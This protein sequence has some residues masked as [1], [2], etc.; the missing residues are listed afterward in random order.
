MRVYFSH[1]TTTAESL[2][3]FSQET[4]SAE[5]LALVQQLKEGRDEASVRLSDLDSKAQ[6]V[7]AALATT[8]HT[9]RRKATRYHLSLPPTERV[10]QKSNQIISF[11]ISLA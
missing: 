5:L 11:S 3:Y 8:S 10:S 7:A 1:A 6:K 2:V 9:H 4:A